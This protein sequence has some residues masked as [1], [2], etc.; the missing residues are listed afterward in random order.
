MN[1]PSKPQRIF[2]PVAGR[3]RIMGIIGIACCALFCIEG[4]AESR[5]ESLTLHFHDPAVVEF[6]FAA[7]KGDAAKMDK[8]LAAGVKVDCRADDGSTPLMVA[9]GLR[10][11]K[12]TMLLLQRKANPNLQDKDDDS[13]M[14]MAADKNDTWYLDTILKN[15]GNPNVESKRYGTTPMK[16]AILGGDFKHVQL[17]VKAGAN[18]NHRDGAGY[19]PII[20]AAAVNDYGLVLYFLQSGADPLIKDNWGGT[21]M[22]YIQ[23]PGGSV[24]TKERDQVVALLKEKKLWRLEK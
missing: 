23:H 10:N 7:L 21:V 24:P 14:S 22:H 15:G 2:P 19:T 20:Q 5:K 4:M 12:A 16:N 11:K 18:L 9:V 13:P 1:D 17:L 3:R 8:L 6:I